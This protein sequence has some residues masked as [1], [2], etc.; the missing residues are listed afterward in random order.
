MTPRF[1]A[2]Q[3]RPAATAHGEAPFRGQERLGN[4]HIEPSGKSL[5]VLCRCCRYL[6]CVRFSAGSARN[7]NG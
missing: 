4:E 1:G 2:R 6:L 5:K 3:L 7:V